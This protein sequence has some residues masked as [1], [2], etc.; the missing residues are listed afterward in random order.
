MVHR[1]L[2]LDYA[3]KHNANKNNVTDDEEL[4]T[5]WI[6]EGVSSW[7]FATQSGY[8]QGLFPIVDKRPMS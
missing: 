3:Q 2:L 4:L 5:V 7:I 8:F 1:P 6:G